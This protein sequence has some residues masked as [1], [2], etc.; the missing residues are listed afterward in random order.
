MLFSHAN[1]YRRTALNHHNRVQYNYSF[2]LNMNLLFW[3][4]ARNDFIFCYQLKLVWNNIA[5]HFYSI[6]HHR[7]TDCEGFV[8]LSEPTPEC[9]IVNWLVIENGKCHCKI[10]FILVIS[11]PSFINPEAQY[12][13]LVKVPSLNIRC[14]SLPFGYSYCS[15]ASFFNSVL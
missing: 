14:H 1:L 12:W 9:L 13:T 11:S 5:S 4:P 2:P 7:L 8:M 10:F 3:I 6:H 15:M